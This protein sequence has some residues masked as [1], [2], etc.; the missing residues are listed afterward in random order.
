MRVARIA[1]QR[2]AKSVTS[3]PTRSET[4]TVRGCTIV[5]DW[6]RSRLSAAKRADRPFA[7]RMPSA[8]PTT[9]ATKPMTRPSSTT[10]RSTCRR[11]APSVRRV[12]SSRVR[13]A[14]VI[15]RVLKIT[16]APTKRAIPPNASRK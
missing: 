5:P 1:G 16:K 10:E 15:E 4:I 11:D 13:C 8:T 7:S 12:A 9:E 3:V 2:L 14:I 6:G